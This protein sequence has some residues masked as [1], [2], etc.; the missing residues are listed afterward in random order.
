M[1]PDSPNDIQEAAI[2]YVA[3]TIERLM[4]K[5]G[6][7]A[8]VIS[9][10]VI[11]KEKVLL[12]V[13]GCHLAS[14]GLVWGHQHH[15]KSTA[16]QLLVCPASHSVPCQRLHVLTEVWMLQVHRRCGVKL[17]LSERKMGIMRC[18]DLPG[19]KLAGAGCSA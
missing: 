10:Y 15:T 18:L 3:S 13:G 14:G 7:R 16:V 1:T 11:G 17:H 19:V 8:Y 2:E 5:P 12:E 6:E 4:K 9:T